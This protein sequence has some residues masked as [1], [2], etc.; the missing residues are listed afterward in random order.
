[1]LEAAGAGARPLVPDALCYPEHFPGPYRYPADDPEALVDRL[2]VWLEQGLPPPVSVDAWS[3]AA[4]G[5]LWDAALTDAGRGARP[6]L[7]PGQRI[8]PISPTRP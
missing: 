8:R 1:M 7:Q 6:R 2:E 3:T 4:V 5:P